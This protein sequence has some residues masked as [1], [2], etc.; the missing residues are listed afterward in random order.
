MLQAVGDA[1][2]TGDW[3]EAEIRWQEFQALQIHY[4]ER[5]F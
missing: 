5:I 4:D 3:A 2:A 1:V